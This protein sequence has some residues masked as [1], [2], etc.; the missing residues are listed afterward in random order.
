M[1]FFDNPVALLREGT[2]EI[3]IH[4]E[5][6]TV[7]TKY[8]LYALLFLAQF[9]CKQAINKWP[10][11]GETMPWRTLSGI[12]D[13]IGPYM[14]HRVNNWYMWFSN[15]T[16]EEMRRLSTKFKQS[17]A[18]CMAIGC[19]CHVVPNWSP[20]DTSARS[21]TKR[22]MPRTHVRPHSA[23]AADLP[24]TEHVTWQVLWRKQ[25]V[26]RFEEHLS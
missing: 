25:T 21:A 9:V 22:W 6:A 1:N 20:P 17:N 8:C 19:H 4:A 3:I 5:L 12:F 13:A 7:V 23:L 11:V 14:S 18:T 26:D 10:E 24:F 15:L 16:P 2:R